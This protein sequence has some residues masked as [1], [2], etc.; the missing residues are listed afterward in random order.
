[1]GTIV[2]LNLCNTTYEYNTFY[3]CFFI[4]TL[5]TN[6][7][8][9]SKITLVFSFYEVQVNLSETTTLSML[10]AIDRLLFRLVIW[11]SFVDLGE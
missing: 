9:L 6:S 11:L 1:M 8:E 5:L 2:G 7:E 10:A 4:V 3:S